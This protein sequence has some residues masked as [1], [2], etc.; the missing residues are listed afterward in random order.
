[1][2]WFP[3]AVQNA[4]VPIFLVGTRNTNVPKHTVRRCDEKGTVPNELQVT[5]ADDFEFNLPSSIVLRI[6]DF[7]PN[8]DLVKCQLV[9]KLF[10]ELGRHSFVWRNR[11]AGSVRPE[12]VNAWLQDVYKQNLL[13]K[14]G[15]RRVAYME[16]T[17]SKADFVRVW[18]QTFKL[19]HE[20]E[21]KLICEA[22][23]KGNLHF[24]KF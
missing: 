21:S 19:V 22:G 13:E 15:F 8:A 6:F 17:D 10:R 18:K 7:L 11:A 23:P 1:M 5:V 12:E 2:H 14:S 3:H 4:N 9:S 16:L 20:N 24:K